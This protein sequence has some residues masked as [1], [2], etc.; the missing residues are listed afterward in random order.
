[1]L[2]EM[3]SSV[4]QPDG[5]EHCVSVKMFIGAVSTFRQMLSIRLNTDIPF[6]SVQGNQAA[7]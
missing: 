2:C 6:K 1:M 4:T 3:T 7:D 5:A